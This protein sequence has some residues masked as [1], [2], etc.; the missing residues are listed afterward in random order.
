MFANPAE[1]PLTAPIKEPIPAIEES[2]EVQ[3]PPATLSV[4]KIED[5][6]QTVEDP[7]TEPTTG[8]GN[9]ETSVLAELLPHE[10]VNV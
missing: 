4:I 2:L 5:P 6:V 1:T 7:E 3:T 8:R 9:I 10:F